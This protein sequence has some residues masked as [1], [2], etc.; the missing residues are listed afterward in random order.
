MKGEK[1]VLRKIVKKKKGSQRRK[2]DA[3]YNS[4]LTR[5]VQQLQE[6]RHWEAP[7]WYFGLRSRSNRHVSSILCSVHF[8]SQQSDLCGTASWAVWLAPPSVSCSHTDSYCL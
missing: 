7:A 2:E 3:A 4:R 8:A 5:M 1:D 6:G